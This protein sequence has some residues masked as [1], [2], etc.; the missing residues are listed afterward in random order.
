LRFRRGSCGRG[1]DVGAVVGAGI[2]ADVTDMTAPSR[3][4]VG[5]A[6][7]RT[8]EI[9]VL[10]LRAAV[11]PGRARVWAKVL[12]TRRARHRRWRVRPAPLKPRVERWFGTLL[13]VC[14]L[15]PLRLPL[16][17]RVLSHPHRHRRLRFRL[18]RNFAVVMSNWARSNV[19]REELL[20]LVEA[21]QLPPLT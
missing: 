13:S 15:S 5:S 8:T 4:R 21:G 18:A 14:F 11:S 17:L 20:C 19:S 2:S 3:S 10:R 6:S 1:G 9:E 7:L 12:L 16:E